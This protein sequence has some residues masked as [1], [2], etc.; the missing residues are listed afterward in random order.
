MA[1]IC[2]KESFT[3]SGA[4]PATLAA[5]F[6]LVYAIIAST[7]NAVSQTFTIYDS[8]AAS[9]DILFQMTCHP[10]GSVNQ[11]VFPQNM[12]L[13]FSTGLTIDPGECDV[14]IIFKS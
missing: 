4:D 1:L 14:F 11:I 6:G 7:D 2:S 5:G 9:G 10:S 3:A 13:Q 8:L 12:A